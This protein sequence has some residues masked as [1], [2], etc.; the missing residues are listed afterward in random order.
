MV[1]AT[2]RHKVVCRRRRSVIALKK[3]TMAYTRTNNNKNNNNCFRR[4]YNLVHT[5]N[6]LCPMLH[7]KTP[8]R[9]WTLS[10]DPTRT[11]DRRW[12]IRSIAARNCADFRQE[13]SIRIYPARCNY[14]DK[15]AFL[16]SLCLGR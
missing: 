5:W 13:I 2:T 3:I 1:N 15:V 6:Q 9:I 10:T 14:L 16:F 12:R 8:L 7:N 11:K 4:L